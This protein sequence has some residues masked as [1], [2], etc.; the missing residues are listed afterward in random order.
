MGQHSIM[1]WP[2]RGE[3]R[4]PES[5]TLERVN[6]IHRAG[7]CRAWRMPSREDWKSAAV[8]NDAA[9]EER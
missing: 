8:S 6:V 9:L 5:V 7:I 3:L 4:P 1:R 2:D